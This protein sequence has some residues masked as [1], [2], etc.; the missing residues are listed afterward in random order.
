M[1]NLLI[2]K[3]FTSQIIKKPIKNRRTSGIRKAK[4]TIS[5]NYNICPEGGDDTPLLPHHTTLKV[6][7]KNNMIPLRA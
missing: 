2:K 1:Q 7:Q 5:S 3:Q 4:S 6:A